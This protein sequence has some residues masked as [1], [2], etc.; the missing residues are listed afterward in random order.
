[1]LISIASWNVNGIIHRPDKVNQVFKT[2]EPDFLHYINKHH[3]VGL[4]ETKIGTSEKIT[5]NGYVTE[6][7]GRKIS[8]NG[9]YYGGICIAI[10]NSIAAGVSV[11][12]NNGETEFLWARLDKD[13]FNIN[14]DLYVCFFY[15]SPEKGTK[16]FGIEVYDRIIDDVAE[17]CS[18]GKCLILGDMNAHT[19]ENPDFINNDE[20]GNGLIQL[21]DS[22]EGG[23]SN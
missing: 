13:F 11:L 21:P 18:Q 10:K 23:F 19:N 7:I 17:Y 8:T 12:K 20:Q 1:M 16:N 4:L 3:I 15:A 6:Q 9:R 5:I 14:R 2:D 22:Y